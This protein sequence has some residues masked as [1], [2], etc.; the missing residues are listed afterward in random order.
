MTVLDYFLTVA[1]AAV[2]AAVAADDVLNQPLAP[3]EVRQECPRTLA[4]EPLATEFGSAGI[5]I[6]PLDRV[7]VWPS[8]P[9]PLRNRELSL[10]L[11]PSHPLLSVLPLEKLF[12]GSKNLVEAPKPQ[13]ISRIGAS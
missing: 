13:T 9:W 7:P 11:P 4:E 6:D 1:I 3:L 5:M 8:T 2:T 12:C 10:I